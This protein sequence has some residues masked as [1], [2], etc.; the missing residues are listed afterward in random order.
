MHKQEEVVEYMQEM[1]KHEKEKLYGKLRKLGNHLHNIKVLKSGGGLPAVTYR[2][3]GMDGTGSPEDYGPCFN[4]YGYYPRRQLW[5]HNKSS[6]FATKSCKK[7]R[8]M[9][10]TAS[11]AFLPKTHG[12]SKLLI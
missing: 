12:G 8:T 2:P 3:R 7:E 5:C 11:Y 9:F 10:V 4:C 1:N 6:K